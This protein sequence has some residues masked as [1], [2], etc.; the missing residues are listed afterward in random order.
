MSPSAAPCS[1]R[2]PK[3]NPMLWRHSE[4]QPPASVEVE[5]VLEESRDISAA[6]PAPAARRAAMF[7]LPTVTIGLRR[8]WE[9]LQIGL[10]HLVELATLEP[11]AVTMRAIVDLDAVLGTRQQGQP[12]QRAE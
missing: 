6:Q 3:P 4:P 7:S 1:V 2:A 9:H 11:G 12:M 10:D 5:E 8:R